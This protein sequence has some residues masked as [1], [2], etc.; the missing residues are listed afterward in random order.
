M[1]VYKAALSLSNKVL[2]TQKI[3]LPK[4]DILFKIYRNIGIYKF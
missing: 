2:N 1:R 4:I 3:S